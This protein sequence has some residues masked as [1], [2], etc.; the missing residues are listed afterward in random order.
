MPYL[1][2]LNNNFGK[3]NQSS[4]NINEKNQNSWKAGN[5]KEPFESREERYPV[6]QKQNNFNKNQN[7]YQ[8]KQPT[9]PPMRR[10]GSE[11]NVEYVEEIYYENEDVYQER[12]KPRR[13][14]RYPV[15]QK[16]HK[17]AAHQPPM[18]R[19]GSERNI[20]YVEEIPIYYEDEVVYQKRRKPRNNRRK[21]KKEEE[22]SSCVLS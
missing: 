20:Q 4:S 22:D 21:Q 11:K 2:P 9:Q 7:R 1:S 19:Y 8:G 3:F 10:Y 17:L 15:Q 12:R 6:Q 18:R 16:Q 14:E 5:I 13:E